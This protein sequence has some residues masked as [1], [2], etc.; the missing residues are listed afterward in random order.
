MSSKKILIIDDEPDM[1]THLSA[2]F[3]DNGYITCSANDGEAGMKKVIH[4]KPDC[5]TLDLVMPNETGVKFLK[6]IKSDS[7]LKNIPLIIVSGLADFKT[8]IKKCKPVP[9]PEGFIDK[10]VNEEAILAKVKE[11]LK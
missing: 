4:E 1:V 7:N 9:E 11:L 5:I 2:L 3:E 10:P 8:F 6:K